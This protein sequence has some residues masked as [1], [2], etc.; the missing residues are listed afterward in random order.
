MVALANDEPWGMIEVAY[1][2]NKEGEKVWFTL[3]HVL[4]GNSIS[5]CQTILWLMNRFFVSSAFLSSTLRS[6]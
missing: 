5:V 1:V 6:C 4:T 3:I 2:E